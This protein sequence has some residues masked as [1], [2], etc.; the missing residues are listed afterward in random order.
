MLKCSHFFSFFL[1]ILFCS[2][3]VENCETISVLAFARDSPNAYRME[4][5]GYAWGEE[6]E[7]QK[8]DIDGEQEHHCSPHFM[9]TGK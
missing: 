9:V 4:W 1:A 8:V 2:G 7:G 3:E 6:A 5:A